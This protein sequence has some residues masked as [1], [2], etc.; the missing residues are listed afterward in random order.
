MQFIIS[1]WT[2]SRRAVLQ[3]RRELIGVS[4]KIIQYHLL[5]FGLTHSTKFL[6]ISVVLGF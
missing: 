3:V 2:Q 6:L 4:F 1:L 5:D